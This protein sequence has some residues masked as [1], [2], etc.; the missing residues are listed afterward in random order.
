MFLVSMLALT[1]VSAA[2][3]QT[4]DIACADD[5][6]CEELDIST[7]EILT[8]NPTIADLNATINDNT[9]SEITLNS[10]YTYTESDSC[11]ENGIIINRDLTIDGN[12]CTIDGGG[13]IRIFHVTG[14]NVTFKN[15]TL[16][17]G[18]TD[19]AGHGGAIW[20]EDNVNVTAIDCTFKN[21]YATYGG[22]VENVNAVNCIFYKNTAVTDGGAAYKVTA[23]NCEFYSNHA[24]FGGAIYIPPS[25]DHDI[26][27]CIFV[28][29]TANT[30]GG[31]IYFQRVE[32]SII[33][34]C[35]FI[36]NTAHTDQ[37][38][39]SSDGGAVYITLGAK[40]TVSTCTFVNNTADIFGANIY[41]FSGSD[42]VL[43]K[44]IIVSDS[45]N[46]LYFEYKVINAYDNWFGNN[47]TNYNVRPAVSS[48]TNMIS[49]LFLNATANPNPVEIFNTSEIIFDLYSYNPSSGEISKYDF[50]DS[51][52]ILTIS[53]TRDNIDKDTAIFGEVIKYNATS[54]GKD[55]ITAKFENFINTIEISV[56]TGSFNDLKN[57]IDNAEGS[58]VTLQTNYS[59]YDSDISLRHG[60]TINR[61][62][63]IDGNG[64]TIDGSGKARIFHVTSGT[65]IF[66]NI[67]FING[68][69]DENGYGGAIW[70]E[71]NVDATATDCTFNNNSATFGGAVS[72]CIVVNSTFNSNHAE[73]D[74][75]AA[76][77]GNAKNCTFN[78]NTAEYE[79]GAISIGSAENCRFNF[80]TADD[81]GA[82]SYGN[83]INCTFNSNHAFDEGGAIFKGYAENS[84]FNSNTAKNA[85]AI[86]W[87]NNFGRIT[88]CNFVN[89]HANEDGGAVVWYGAAGIISN[90][91]FTDNTANNTG[92]AIEWE[93]NNGR[94][95]DCNFVNNS[96]KNYAGAIEWNLIN[97]GVVF[98][99]TFVNNSA[100][101]GSAILWSDSTNGNISHCI[102]VNNDANT[103]AIQCA[104]SEDS[105][106]TI[107]NNIFL[108][109]NGADIYFNTNDNTSNVD[110]NWFG[111]NAN[112]Y[113]HAPNIPNVAIDTWI[114]LNATANPD[115]IA[116]LNSTDIVFKLY[117]YNLTSGAISYYDHGLLMPVRLTITANDG[118]ANTT[119]ASLGEPVRFTA[120]NM[121]A[122]ITATIENTAFTFKLDVTGFD[123]MLS[124]E[125]KEVAYSENTIIALSYN[126]SATG[127]VNITLKGKK[128]NLTFTN[129]DLNTQISLG[130]V[131][132]DEY[133][134][135]VAYS[136][137]GYFYNATANATLKVNK[138]TTQIT[139]SPV[140]A[141]YNSNKYL[142]VTLKD[143]TGKSVSGAE[144]TVNLNGVKT[145]TTDKNG[146]IKINVAK[147]VPKT[148]AAK[149][150]FAENDRYIGS[151]ANVKVTVKK[152]K[153]KIVAKKKTF[154]KAKKVKKYTITLKSGRT[155]IK[156]VQVTLKVKGK[157]YKAK[158]T[159]K[160]KATFKIKKLTKKG[161][162]KAT[163]KFKGNKY[164]NK[165][166][167]KVK[168]KIK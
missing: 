9:H 39:S 26:K 139:T 15:M 153:S 56:P 159:A 126:S 68:Y 10:D 37:P 150:T 125:S 30:C 44:S 52:P 40:I 60:I 155:P 79:G 144:V 38:E 101:G 45:D 107:A 165:A 120:D 122:G 64:Y 164:Y 78:F 2:E 21:N 123:S 163:I 162:F 99:C 51:K 22:A 34:T 151:S 16:I 4:S 114:F 54:Y 76:Y 32:N 20:A 111:N 74:G 131:L 143:I 65:V 28:N 158:T 138:Q 84:L 152:A 80:N 110:Y 25:T 11:F 50:G 149:I 43:C 89:N 142:I 124:A 156:K 95:T 61:D 83:A 53:S 36:N 7:D 55:N 129:L 46:S 87:S 23:T 67:T 100:S 66:K 70:A 73:S 81:G 161:T 57:L 8:S 5:N 147:L 137:D 71:N 135:D 105:N 47:A 92:G 154:K 127:K 106:L 90:C 14:G 49:W 117:T 91:N 145:Y 148:Y 13:K 69:T 108:N 113:R 146:Q 88:G 132:P 75:G 1:A 6:I 160:G 121:Y 116:I 27:D 128:Y 19:Y 168:I 134:V 12:G 109:N 42:S 18:W 41:W 77:Q 59:Y 31:A 35:V 85:G 103:G 166:T 130:S 136:G 102:F 115:T 3:N 140:T 82:I 141:T 94:I 98:N 86:Y 96:A 58:T 63:T 97:I 48:E 17:N 133:D 62:L 24:T 157:T 29:N 167:K 112:T 33:S 72:H 119:M 104:N 93:G 118:K